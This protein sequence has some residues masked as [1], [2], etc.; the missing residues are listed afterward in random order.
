MPTILSRLAP[1]LLLA[2]LALSGCRSTADLSADPVATIESA[3][4]ALTGPPLDWAEYDGRRVR[5]EAPLTVSGNHRLLRSG[6]LVASFDG[7]LR[8]PTEVAEPGPAALALGKDNDRR[9]IVLALDADPT[10]DATPGAPPAWRSGT[11][12]QGVEGI[13][14]VVQGR[15]VLNVD[16][17][18]HAKPAPRPA[19]PEV[20]STAMATAR[21]SRHRAGRAATKPTCISAPN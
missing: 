8:A 1:S 19:V 4:A 17:P 14:N 3:P 20:C 18:L 15:A 10:R 9:R 2:L 13:V 5:I 16:R 11:R 6:E 7:R 12:L 21:A